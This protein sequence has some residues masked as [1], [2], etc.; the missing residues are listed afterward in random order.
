MN[1]L[2]DVFGTDLA[3]ELVSR[4][5]IATS[6]HWKGATVFWQIDA[7][8]KVR[9]GKI[10]LY[11]SNTGKRVKEPFNHIT[12]V[13][14]ALKMTGFEL[15]QCLFGEHLLID[16]LKPVALVESEKSAVIASA[17]LPQFLWLAVGSLNN[18]TRKNAT[19]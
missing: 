6:K 2:F 18:L 10:M 13:H 19:L 3:S 12:W 9:T 17:Y 16:K 8:G 7:L 14:K 15:R 4:Y 11:G 5:F 1:F